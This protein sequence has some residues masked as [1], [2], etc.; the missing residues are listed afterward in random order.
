[1][2]FNPH[3]HHRRS[4]RLKGYDYSQAG[5]YFI[6]IC[7]HDGECRFGKIIHPGQMELNAYGIIAYNEWIK[8][9]DRF[10]NF[11]SDVFQIM[12]NHIHAI[13]ILK[14]NENQ[15]PQVGVTLAVTPLGTTE[16][17]DPVVT[18]AV[19]PL[20]TTESIDPV[21]TL[22]VTPVGTTESIDRVVTL[23]V[24]PVGTTESIDPVVTPTVTPLL[25]TPKME[26]ATAR[27]APTV[28]NIVGAY[29]S[30]VAKAC[31]EVYKS[32]NGDMG[33]LW[34]RNFHEHII[35]NEESYQNIADYIISNP[36]NWTEDKF[37]KP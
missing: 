29:K 31:L 6:T 10:S 22:A 2:T 4:I 8:L 1:M 26:R 3:I 27:V 18:L 32:N 7:C 35:R 23:A 19:T 36:V 21:V 33:K 5:A 37:Y 28:G 15:S 12:P 16:S 17:I 20:G 11:K 13:I 24:T 30:L 34:Q 9:S 14:G 25:T